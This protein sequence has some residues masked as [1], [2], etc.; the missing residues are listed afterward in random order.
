MKIMGNRENQVNN[1]S[2]NI[3]GQNV[4]ESPFFN[5]AIKETYVKLINIAR[6]LDIFDENNIVDKVMNLM[7]VNE[8]LSDEYSNKYINAIF[9]NNES[10]NLF[11][12][13]LRTNESS[14]EEKINELKAKMEEEFLEI[15]NNL[16]SVQQDAV[17]RYREQ[18]NIFLPKT[19]TLTLNKND[20]RDEL[21]RVVRE[22]NQQRIE[23]NHKYEEFA[24]NLTGI[25][26]QQQLRFKHS[27]ESAIEK[28]IYDKANI[29]ET[30]LEKI[31][32]IEEEFEQ[33]ET[34]QLQ[35]IHEKE[36]EIINKT[37]KLNET[38]TKIGNE[39]ES[40]LKYGYIP[41]DIKIN[42]FVD[43]IS[44]NDKSYNLIEEQVLTEFKTHLQENDI[45]IEELKEKHKVIVD[46]YLKELRKLKKSFNT[47]LQ[48]EINLI[49]KKISTTTSSPISK[50]ESR[51]IIKKLVQEKKQL[52]KKQTKLKFEKIKELQNKYLKYEM[53]YIEKYEILRSKKIECEAIKSSAMKNVNYERV[54]H[55]ERINSEIKQVN[56]EKESFS[57]LDHYEGIKEI[58]DNRYKVEIENES[59][60]YDI[61]E[62]ELKI[63]LE[64]FTSKYK[65]DK[66]EAEKEYNKMLSDADLIY[67]EESIKNRIDYFNVK[68]MLEID[69][70]KI[71]TKYET[72]F[73]NEK[74]EYERTKLMYYNAC[75]NIQYE[76]Y[77]NNNDLVY[78][79]IDEDVKYEQDLAEILKNSKKAI[80]KQEINYLTNENRYNE[81]LLHINLYKN[82]FLVEKTMLIELFEAYYGI[83]LKISE[84]ESYIHNLVS[85]NS[86]IEFNKNKKE[87]LI[88][89]EL[90]RQIKLEVLRIYFNKVIQILNTRLNFEKG[91]KFNKQIENIKKELATLLNEL[92]SKIENTN[93]KISSY[94]NTILISLETIKSNKSEIFKLKNKALLT[95]KRTPEFNELKKQ[96]EHLEENI[97]LLKKQM[98]ANINNVRKL[99]ALKRKQKDE[100]IQKERMYNYRLEKLYRSQSNEEK[101]YARL[102]NMVKSNLNSLEQKLLKYGQIT[103]VSKYLYENIEKSKELISI[104]NEEIKIQSEN[105]FDISIQKFEQTF[106][107]NYD[108]QKELYTKNFKRHIKG[109]KETIDIENKE[110]QTNVTTITNA[111]NL[112]IETLK[113]QAKYKENKL[114]LELKKTNDEYLNNL[115][116]HQHK[117]STIENEKRLEL[118]CHEENYQMYQEEFEKKNSLIINKYLAKISEIKSNYKAQIH[119]IESKYK[120]MIKKINNQHLINISLRKNNESTTSNEYKENIRKTNL[121]ISNNNQ[122]EKRLR[123]RHEENKHIRYK[124]FL[125]NQ[126]NTRHEFNLQ[127]KQ[128]KQKCNQRIKLLQYDFKK[129]FKYKKD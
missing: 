31:K 27:Y 109:L 75:S 94:K 35:I 59:I 53:D 89:L 55:H 21:Y 85:S 79:L 19:K 114:L 25:N 112:V 45:E 4:N 69:K 101:I 66:I 26:E 82:R 15:N 90:I 118:L 47:N 108:L 46:D 63:Y 96:I 84:F 99:N 57:T 33:F 77:K 103:S 38:I 24:D 65:I 5:A 39:Y 51:K 107:T 78:K 81:N 120:L 128:I 41:Y 73:A 14:L 34:D 20:H 56:I 100:I 50:K 127:I 104:I 124:L 61:N 18:E 123:L 42:K 72:L 37:I 58:Y 12:N 67:Q 62:I 17:S 116:N 92:N 125:L 13:T 32:I 113:R 86:E 115:K 102:I 83:T 106:S 43:E 49:D 3:N 44:E 2:H 95:K 11:L 117:V 129:K 111:Y 16:L 74:I 76:L 64:K 71:I 105:Y 110:Y 97:I 9:E 52:I 30:A 8:Q 48:K 36:K 88:S 91:I 122:N 87:I 23:A 98:K 68:T 6:G 10:Y 22:I 70:E 121:K 54:Y 119:N 7:N 80:L 40:R 28:N 1:N 60:K 126:K 93:K 29:D